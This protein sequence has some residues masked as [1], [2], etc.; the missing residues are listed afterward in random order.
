MRVDIILLKPGDEHIL[1]RVARDVF[2]GPVDPALAREFIADRRH[3]IVV[4]IEDNVVVGMVTAVDYIHPDKKPQLWINEVGVAPTHQR[5][6]IARRMLE[7]MLA[8]GRTLG[9]TEAWVGTDDKNIAART[10][11]ENVGGTP[12]SCVLYSF[13]LAPPPSEDMID[14]GYVPTQEEAELELLISYLQGRLTSEQGAE[15]R[16]RL[17]E[18]AAFQ[19]NVWAMMVT[20]SVPPKSQRLL[21]P[22]TEMERECADWVRRWVKTER[23]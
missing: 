13:D 10:L 23:R 21:R 22:P 16:R 4:A 1:D 2:D 17:E 14:D 19:Q 7:T 5:R 12:E 20:W 6:G 18:D 15:V 8:H 3:H 11:Y 9:C